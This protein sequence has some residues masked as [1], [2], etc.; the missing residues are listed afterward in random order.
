MFT[1]NDALT[2]L[3]DVGQLSSEELTPEKNLIKDLDLDSALTLELLM[4]LEEQLN[5][6][7]SEVEAAKLVTVGDVLA[8]VN[9]RTGA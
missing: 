3:A 9:E 4:T 2:I 6:Q 7:I 5:T 1:A 8:L